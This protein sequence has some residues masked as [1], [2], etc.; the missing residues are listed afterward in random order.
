MGEERRR[1]GGENEKGK[2]REEGKERRKKGKREKEKANLL[3]KVMN[4][5]ILLS[6]TNKD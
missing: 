6:Y 4:N 1:G 2:E 3:C 5:I